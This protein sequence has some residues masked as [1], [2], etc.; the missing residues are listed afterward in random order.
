[1]DFAI[2]VQRVS[3]S[4]QTRTALWH[5]NSRVNALHQ[6]SF[7]VKSGQIF[8]L[9][10]PNGAGKTTLLK[11][12][13]TLVLPDEGEVVMAGFPVS[14]QAAQIRSTLSYAMGEEKSFYWRLTAR[15]NL[16]FFADLYNIPARER[17]SKIQEV[18]AVTGLETV[19]DRPYEELSTGFRQRVA[20][21]RSFLN[22]ASIVLADEPTRSLDP[23]SRREIQTLLRDLSRKWGKTLLLTTHD[24]R[25]ARELGDDI[26][27]LHQGR[28]HHPGN[29][30]EIETFF[31]QLCSPRETHAQA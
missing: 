29:G 7:Q 17:R 28:F 16:E 2:D 18:A 13:S 12:L 5:P 1:M 25:E 11:I 22:N 23:V 9:V 19:L 27:L 4:F 31:E 26:G 8:A 21:A 24:L 15:Q 6:V 10:G 14:R 20:L 30:R 3:K